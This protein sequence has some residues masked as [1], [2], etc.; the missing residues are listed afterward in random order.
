MNLINPLPLSDAVRKQKHL[1]QRIFS[2]QYSHG[3]K[4]KTLLE[5]WNL[6]IHAFPKA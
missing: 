4:K 5:T 3:I 2:V 1:F 6:I